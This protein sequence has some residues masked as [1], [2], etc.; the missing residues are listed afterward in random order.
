[1]KILIIGGTAFIGPAVVA[2]LL[3]MGHVVTVFHRGKTFVDMP[4]GVE[5]IRGDRHEMAQYRDTFQRI[6]PDVVLDMIPLVEEDARLLMNT[7]DGLPRRVVG[8]SSVD[9]YRAYDRLEGFDPGPLEPIPLSENSPLRDR[10][11][12]YRGE[13]PRAADD[14]RRWLDD[15]DKIPVE[16]IIMGHPQMPGTILRLPMVYGPRDKQHRL[17]EYLKRMDDGRPGIIMDEGMA[18]WRWTR[19]YVDNIAAAIALGVSDDRAAGRI[20]NVG[21]DPPLSMA[22]WVR[23]IGKA[24]GWQGQVVIVPLKDLPLHLA[25]NINTAQDLVAD[26]TRI[27]TELGYREPVSLEDALVR[28]VEWE[29]ANPPPEIDPAHFDYAAEDRVLAANS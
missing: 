15:Y 22:E 13:T 26:S 24:A 1:M 4:A 9:V 19:S 17:F 2:Q 18:N 21:E 6:A 11:Y 23:L 14:P 25:S 20:Y 16:Q 5:Q 28:T 10:L 8:I 27:R 3:G 12:P 29:R 7:M